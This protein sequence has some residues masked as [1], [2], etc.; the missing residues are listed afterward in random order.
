[1]RKHSGSKRYDLANDQWLPAINLSDT[2]TAF[3]IDD[4]FLFIAYGGSIYR[5]DKDGTGEGLVEDF[6]DTIHALFTDDEI[7]FVFGPPFEKALL[8]HTGGIVASAS[9]SQDL[10][11][12]TAVSQLASRNLFAGVSNLSP[13]STLVLLEYKANGSFSLPLTDTGLS[14]GQRTF[15]WP[16]GSRIAG[17]TG[18]VYDCLGLEHIGSF[19]TQIDDLDFLRG[20]HS[21]RPVRQ[22][23][24]LLFQVHFPDW[25]QRAEY[26]PK[27]LFTCMK[28]VSSPFTPMKMLQMARMSRSLRSMN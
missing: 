26:R 1:M 15:A 4:E 3:H 21:D 25:I 22:S 18:N 13:D 6:D 19:D 12:D 10:H 28:T 7:L 27:G 2:P 9:D 14:M 5:Y 17:S 8:K 20:R 23:N 16:N 24:Q 11:L